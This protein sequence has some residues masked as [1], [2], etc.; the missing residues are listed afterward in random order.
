MNYVAEIF[1][2]DTEKM[3]S[4]I[5]VGSPAHNVALVKF[6]SYISRCG[7]CNFSCCS[8]YSPASKGKVVGSRM[9]P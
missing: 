6:I 8:S 4:W 1:V 3:F 9:L 2:T 7:R 5:N